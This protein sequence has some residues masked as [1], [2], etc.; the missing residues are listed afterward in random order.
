LEEKNKEFFIEKE[1]NKN[2]FDYKKIK[3]FM[4]YINYRLINK[5]INGNKCKSKKC[6]IT[7]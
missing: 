6:S 1:L 2:D 7:R 3:S 5:F 4:K